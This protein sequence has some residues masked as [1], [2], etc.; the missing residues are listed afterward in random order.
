M[1]L[2]APLLAGG[3]A[4][5]DGPLFKTMLTKTWT[6]TKDAFRNIRNNLQKPFNKVTRGSTQ[7]LV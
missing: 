2:H 6:T 7:V 5:D 3:V 4:P 1:D